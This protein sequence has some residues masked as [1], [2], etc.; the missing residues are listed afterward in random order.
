MDHRHRRVRRLFLVRQQLHLLPPLPF[1]ATDL[2]ISIEKVN[3]TVTS[4]LV[5]SGIFP[6]ITGSA[7]DIY[8]RRPVLIVSLGAYTVVNVALALQRNFVALFV[9][10][11]KS[12]VRERV[13]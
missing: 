12:V 2:G 8:G 9:L 3:L 4:Y 1:L 5:A 7:A 10:R 11:R 6:S 13:S